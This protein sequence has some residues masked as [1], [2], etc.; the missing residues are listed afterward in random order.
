VHGKLVLPENRLLLSGG[1]GGADCEYDGVKCA[2]VSVCLDSGT[3]CDAS[4][5]DGGQGFFDDIWNGTAWNANPEHGPGIPGDEACAGRSFCMILDPPGQAAIT[6]DWKNNWQPASVNL[7]AACHH[8][9]GCDRPTHLA[10]GTSHF[11]IALPA[12]NPSA[13]LIWNGKK[14][15]IARIA[16]P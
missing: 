1:C 8:L 7:T 9:A 4:D 10:C 13:A 11:C 16:Q 3:F 6:R 2:S 15:G 5:C 14:W 12:P